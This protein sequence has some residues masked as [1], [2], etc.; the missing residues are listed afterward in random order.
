MAN[1]VDKKM[2]MRAKNRILSVIATAWFAILAI[3]IIF[4]VFAGL[5]ASFRPGTELIRKG[6]SIDLD[7]AGTTYT[8]SS[9]GLD[10][11]F[12]YLTDVVVNPGS[13]VTID[14]LLKILPGCS[15]TLEEGANL[16][17]AE[18]K[19]LYFYGA[20]SYKKDYYWGT[21]ATWDISLPATLVNNGATITSNGKVASTDDTFSNVQ[22]F[23]AD[24]D[25]EVIVDEYNQ[26]IQDKE[27]ENP[28]ISVAFHVGT[29]K[30]PTPA[31]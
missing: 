12:G 29:P 28:L 22:G 25:K 19:A 20:D 9:L 13:S 14:N 26:Y 17:L 11:P 8:V 6:L 4:P 7:V 23:T 10:C 24:G 1:S 2:G 3:I 30:T 5:L 21:A 31:E 16:T 15:I 18:G 27:G